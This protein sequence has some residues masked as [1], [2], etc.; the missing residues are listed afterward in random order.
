M[1][2]VSGTCVGPAS[3]LGSSACQI[4]ANRMEVSLLRH[5]CTDNMIV[6]MALASKRCFCAT[7]TAWTDTGLLSCHKKA[8]TVCR[9]PK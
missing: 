4:K 2:K 5:L 3:T 9:A 8:K 1:D 6:A 7:K